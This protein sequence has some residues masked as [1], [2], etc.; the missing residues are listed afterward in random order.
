MRCRVQE[1]YEREIKE[2]ARNVLRRAV[3]LENTMNRNDFGS[4]HGEIRSLKSEMDDLF[5]L[6]AV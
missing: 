2:L 5:Y 1:Q 6:Y 4:M 3:R